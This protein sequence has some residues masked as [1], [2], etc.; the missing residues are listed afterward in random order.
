MGFGI[1]GLGEF[2]V[3]G[4]DVCQEILY[5]NRG[6]HLV[7]ANAHIDHEVIAQPLEH[8]MLLDLGFRA[9]RMFRGWV[10][11]QV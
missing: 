5:N 10:H 7:E 4:S 3:K 6:G 2:R 8:R 1:G 9:L 11:R